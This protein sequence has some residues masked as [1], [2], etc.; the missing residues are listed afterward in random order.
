M[1][2]AR[3]WEGGWDRWSVVVAIFVSFLLMA[4]DG[5]APVFFLKRGVGEGVGVFQKSFTWV[6]RL[7]TVREQNRRLLDQ[8]G[9]LSIEENRYREA[10]F[11]NGRLRQLLGFKE[12]GEINFIPAEVIG[13]GTMGM[14]GAVH[15]NVGW[16]DG[17]RKDMAMVTGR[18]VV[19]KLVSVGESFSVG[20]LLTDPGCRISAK[21]QRSRVLGIVRWLYGNVCLLEGVP[22]RSDVQVGDLV[23]TSGYSRVYPPGFPIG[24]VLETSS[25]KDG[26]FLRVLLRTEVDFGVVEEVLLLRDVSSLE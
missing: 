6:P 13:T 11:E 19:G 22:L 4:M 7:L 9:R 3:Y 17:C 2:L 24:R 26:L 1:S 15:L 8:V 5:S 18:G 23:V 14:S 10:F 25:E 20:Q 21:I 12:R 16:K